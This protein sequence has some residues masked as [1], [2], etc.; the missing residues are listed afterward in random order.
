MWR[1]PGFN[2]RN[3]QARAAKALP[4]DAVL[5][6]PVSRV[7]GRM[8]AVG[9][10][11]QQLPKAGPIGPVP[12]RLGFDPF[13]MPGCGCTMCGRVRNQK[14]AAQV[15]RPEFN[16]RDLERAF[17]AA[18][19]VAKAGPTAKDIDQA[20]SVANEAGRLAQALRD[21]LC[22]VSYFASQ[23]N[24]R[25]AGGQP[26]R[27]LLDEFMQSKGWTVAGNGHFS[28]A[29][30]KDK[31]CI[32]LGFKSEDSGA[33][34]AAFCRDNAGLK[35]LP[36]VMNIQH[37][38]RHSYTVVMPAF[39]PLDWSKKSAL[40]NAWMNDG[41]QNIGPN[42]LR[43]LRDWRIETAGERI[44]DFFSGVASMDL[45]GDNVM[46]D[47]EGNFIITDPVSFKK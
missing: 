33:V 35:G 5:G 34:Y 17:F 28:V 13:Y 41:G 47:D 31:L 18:P 40:S 46:Q 21:T 23:A 15:R 7:D 32:K 24:N 1:E 11:F 27:N 20:I 19:P 44:R 12:A 25:S 8:V 10:N 14:Q 6:K 37:H 9:P 42:V 36:N 26:H 22:S 45:H 4:L 30:V 2:T 39:K 3:N 38:G 43:L 16:L 29:Y